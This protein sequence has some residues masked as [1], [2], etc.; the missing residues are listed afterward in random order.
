MCFATAYT[1]ERTDV[2]LGDCQVVADEAGEYGFPMNK[3]VRFPWGV[4]LGHFS[5]KNGAAAGAALRQSLGW[6]DQFVILCNRT[7]S[8]IYGV[9]VLA[10]AFVGAVKENPNLRLLLVGGG[11]QASLIQKI[12]APVTEKVVMPGWLEWEALPG[13]YCACDLFVSPSHSDG[14]S[15]S[16]LEALACGRPVLVSDIPGNREW[17]TP[18]EVGA[19]FAD[20]NVESLKKQLLMLAENPDL[21]QYGVRARTLAEERANWEKNF[22]QLL[23]GYH[24]ALRK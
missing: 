19:L 16:L 21:E 17:V 15:I 22:N 11:S 4:D 5:P 18:C 8:P 1:L 9:D 13:A 23:N 12:L 10:E 20:G 3:I 24:L 6:E 2:L 7:W 14:S